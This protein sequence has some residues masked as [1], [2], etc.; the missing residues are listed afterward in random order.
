MNG[1]E[2]ANVLPLPVLAE[3]NIS[4]YLGCSECCNVNDCISVGFSYFFNIK[5]FNNLLCKSYFFQLFSSI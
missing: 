5:F 1:I 3:I 2:N 4:L